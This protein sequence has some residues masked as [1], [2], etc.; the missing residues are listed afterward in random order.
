MRVGEGYAPKFDKYVMC[1]TMNVTSNRENALNNG[2]GTKQFAGNLFVYL[3]SYESIY[4]VLD[5]DFNDNG[6][7][8][9]GFGVNIGLTDSITLSIG[10]AYQ[11][12][13]LAYMYHQDAKETGVHGK[14]SL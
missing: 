1:K 12:S 4:Y 8:T 2:V 7:T 6:T 3:E 10:S 13:H 14:K 5:G 9:S 11:T